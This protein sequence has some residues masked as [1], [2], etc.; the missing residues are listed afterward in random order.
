MGSNPSVPTF[1]DVAAAHERI[2]PHIHRTPILTSTYW[3]GLVGAKLFFK[4]ENFQK[5]GSFKA[6]GATNAVFSLPSGEIVDGVATHSSGNHGAALCFAAGRGEV[7]AAVVMPRTAPSVKKAAVRDYGGQIIECEPTS[8]ARETTLAT[9]VEETGARFVHPY[10]D[11]MVIA[12]Q[13]TCAKEVFEGVSDL[14]ALVVPIGGGGLISGSCLSR[15]AL[16]PKTK[17]YGAE[18]QSANSAY[19]SLKAGQIVAPT[20]PNTVADGLTMP[21]RDLTWAL[22]STGVE[23]VLLAEEGD[24]IAAMRMVWQRMKI[25]IEPSCA[26]PL[27]AMLNNRALFAGRRVGVVLTGGNVDLEA[28]PWPTRI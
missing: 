26:V 25:V 1:D 22:V 24:T 11:P 12:G 2:A 15:D 14:D 8:T 18:P 9:V 7:S 5:A 10:N 3:D 17:I 28:L 23:K 21:L 19:Q 27:A 6:R 16:S 13:G 4:C 20:A